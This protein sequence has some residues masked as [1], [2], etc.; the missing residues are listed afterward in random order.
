M[1]IGNISSTPP[2]KPQHI[3]YKNAKMPSNFLVMGLIALMYENIEKLTAQNQNDTTI[4]PL[5]FDTKADL[6]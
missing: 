5:L 2:E 6:E 3:S 4:N 1:N